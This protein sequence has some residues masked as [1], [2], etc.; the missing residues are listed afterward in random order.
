MREHIQQS[1]IDRQ[2]AG[3]REQPSWELHLAE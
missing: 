1:A 3:F 2:Q